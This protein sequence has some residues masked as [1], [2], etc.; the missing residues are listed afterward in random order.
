MKQDLFLAGQWNHVPL[1][2]VDSWNGKWCTETTKKLLGEWIALLIFW[3][4]N[5]SEIMYKSRSSEK[6]MMLLAKNVF[7]KDHRIFHKI[8]EGYY[9]K[10]KNILKRMDEIEKMPL[11]NLSN[12]KIGDLFLK[13]RKNLGFCGGYD[14]LPF[15]FDNLIIEAVYLEQYLKDNP[16]EKNV[17]LSFALPEVMLPTLEEEIAVLTLAQKSRGLNKEKIKGKYKKEIQEMIQKYKHIS[18][19]I[20]YP[21]KTEDSYA[22][23]IT[24]ESEKKDLNK[25]LKEKKCYVS[26]INKRFEKYKKEKKV[27][28]KIVERISAMRKLSEIRAVGEL[29]S[30]Y[31]F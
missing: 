23:Q 8:M 2:A 31:C 19:L 26:E 30:L 6:E 28:Q 11:M 16:G 29:D 4:D 10:R 18:A 22:E 20:L 21:F 24:K 17:I 3:K 12:K 14:W 9:I 15:S 1:L 5:R 27:P 7:L 25:I 13:T